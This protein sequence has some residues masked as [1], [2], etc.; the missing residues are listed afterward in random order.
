MK[1]LVGETSALS[2]ATAVTDE[3]E[4]DLTDT[5]TELAAAEAER[6]AASANC[7]QIA[8]GHEAAA[9]SCK[10]AREATTAAE[11]TIGADLQRMHL[12]QLQLPA[13]CPSAIPALTFAC[14]RQRPQRRSSRSGRTP[15]HQPILL[16]LVHVRQVELGGKC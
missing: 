8:A 5:T 11:E 16:D 2:A 3:P 13:G 14:V 6:A 1:T 4:G 15:Q 10:D 7:M 12:P 9:A